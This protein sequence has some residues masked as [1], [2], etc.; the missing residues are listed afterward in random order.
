[1]FYLP[2]PKLYSFP[3]KLFLRGVTKEG[4]KF[5]LIVLFLSITEIIE[6]VEFEFLKSIES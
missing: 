2:N 1:M 6:T 5:L 4:D 3:S